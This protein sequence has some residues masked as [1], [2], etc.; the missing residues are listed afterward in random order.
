M[1]KEKRILIIISITLIILLVASLIILL[2]VKGSSKQPTEI[3]NEANEINAENISVSNEV[4]SNDTSLENTISEPIHVGNITPVDPVEDKYA[5]VGGIGL[6][7][8]EAKKTKGIA[9]SDLYFRAV[10]IIKTYNDRVTELYNQNN[11]RPSEDVSEMDFAEGILNTLD[12]EYVKQAGLTKA[13]IS[14][15][16]TGAYDFYPLDAYKNMQNNTNVIVFGLLV[17]KET[18]ECKSYGYVVEMNEGMHVYAIMPY[19][20]MQQIGLSSAQN[21]TNIQFST[22]LLTKND[23]NTYPFS[24]VNEKDRIST[25][26]NA[27]RTMTK[28]SPETAFSKLEPNYKNKFGSVAGY[29]SYAA[30]N[31]SKLDAIKIREVTSYSTQD[32]TTFACYDYNNIIFTIKVNNSDAT[33]FTIEF[34][35][36]MF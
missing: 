3:I 15:V 21:V 26:L 7:N 34:S 14:N 23:Y 24:K 11:G 20:Y 8:A 2:V 4:I 12:P 25:Y 33:D 10:K 31:I 32:E 27:F 13:N 18:N 16:A 1:N 28:Y 22:A 30:S 5:D 17:N 35:N 29:K 6:S 36:I 9:Y 19:E